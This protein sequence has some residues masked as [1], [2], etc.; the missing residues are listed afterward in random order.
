MTCQVHI[1]RLSLRPNLE[2]DTSLVV[3]VLGLANNFLCGSNFTV[4]KKI[5]F[6]KEFNFVGW[7]RKVTVEKKLKNHQVFVC[8]LHAFRCFLLYF[9]GHPKIK[10]RIRTNGFNFERKDTKTAHTQGFFGDQ[11]RSPL[12]PG[13]TSR[14]LA[15]SLFSLAAVPH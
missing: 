3:S 4:T 9:L 2:W 14:I 7:F 13:E 10:H 6:S 8:G 12:W 5:N 1:C 15:G 11:D